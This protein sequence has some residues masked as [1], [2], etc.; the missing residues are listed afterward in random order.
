[1]SVRKKLDELIDWYELNKPDAGRAIKV[2]ATPN[3]IRKFAK[4]KSRGGPFVY[5]EREIVAGRKG[6]LEREAARP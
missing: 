4:R 2:N 3:T 6:L 1:M 5:R